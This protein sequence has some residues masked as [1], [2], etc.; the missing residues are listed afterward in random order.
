VALGP[1]SL[2]SICAYTFHNTHDNV[3]CVAVS[4]DATLMA[5][6][7]SESYVRL[8]SL[9]G[10]KLRGFNSTFKPATIHDS[11]DLDRIREEHGTDSRK[12]IGHSGAVF[13]ASFSPDNKYLISCSEDKT[14]KKPKPRCVTLIILL[15]RY[16]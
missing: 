4:E 16:F 9:K 15:I 12:L 14:G 8:W 7:F 6:G 13:G 1:S 10:T 2:P 3:N 11:D 5:A